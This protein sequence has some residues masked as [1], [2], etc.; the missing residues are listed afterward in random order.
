MPALETASRLL[1]PAIFSS[2][3]DLVP[4]SNIILPFKVITSLAALFSIALSLVQTL[5]NRATIFQGRRIFPRGILI[6]AILRAKIDFFEKG[7]KEGI[8]K[9]YQYFY[10]E[11]NICDIDIYVYMYAV[12]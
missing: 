3:S 4:H 8:R 2:F 1:E 11:Y 5:L 12:T 10:V 6:F 7:G 9:S